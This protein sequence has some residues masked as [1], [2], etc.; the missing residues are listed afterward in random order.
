M[1]IISWIITSKVLSSHR[2]LIRTVCLVLQ[3]RFRKQ[4]GFPSSVAFCYS[5]QVAVSSCGQGSRMR[6]FYTLS[7]TGSGGE[8]W[9]F[10]LVT[11]GYR[12]FYN[13]IMAGC[14]QIKDLQN[15]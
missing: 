12:V 5:A 14:K 10:R 3:D 2:L 15:Q 13:K 9:K 11:H 7:E 1:Y 4:S 8:V 6:S